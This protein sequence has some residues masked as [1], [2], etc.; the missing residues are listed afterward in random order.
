MDINFNTLRNACKYMA[1]SYKEWT[2][3]NHTKLRQG[4]CCEHKNRI[5][6]E[7][8]KNICPLNKKR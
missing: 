6:Y 1:F 3:E 4:F 5:D 8:K 7:C 2:D